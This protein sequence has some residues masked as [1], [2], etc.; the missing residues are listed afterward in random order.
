MTVLRHP[1]PSAVASAET[2]EPLTR[3]F[4]P[5]HKLALGVAVGAVF[6]ATIFAVTVFHV[7]L[8]PSNGLP[9]ILLAQ[10]FYGYQVSWTGALVGLFWGFVSGFV[11]GWF[12]A[13]VRNA[14]TAVTVFRLRTKAELAHTRD[15]LDHI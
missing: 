15:F 8:R 10:Y 5:V 7:V 4:L 2:R 9:M 6:G 13:F 14:A 12:T 3:A 1:T 11:A